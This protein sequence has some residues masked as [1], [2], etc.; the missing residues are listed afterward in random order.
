MDRDDRAGDIEVLHLRARLAAPPPLV[1]AAAC[2]W[3]EP[4]RGALR[5]EPGP[6]RRPNAALR[7]RLGETFS[8]EPLAA[9]DFWR[10]SPTRGTLELAARWRGQSTRLLWTGA[11]MPLAE[12]V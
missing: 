8:V 3:L 7:K 11:M 4:G 1:E 10:Q 12:A 9:L 2:L 6:P 5:L